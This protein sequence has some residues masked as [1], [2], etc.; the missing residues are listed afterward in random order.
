MAQENKIK[1]IYVGGADLY[2]IFKIG[3]Y[4]VCLSDRFTYNYMGA[5]YNIIFKNK[6][7]FGETYSITYKKNKYISDNVWIYNS[8]KI[9]KNKD[10]IK[11]HPLDV[12][13]DCIYLGSADF[14]NEEQKKI[15][16]KDIREFLKDEREHDRKH[17]DF[18][19]N[20]NILFN[21]VTRFE[22]N[23]EPFKFVLFEI[24]ENN[25]I[26]Y[27]VW[28]NLWGSIN[29]SIGN[30]FDDSNH[31][32]HSTY[33]LFDALCCIYSKIKKL[34]CGSKLSPDYPSDDDFDRRYNTMNIYE[35]N[36]DVMDKISVFFKL[37]KSYEN[38]ENKYPIQYDM[39]LSS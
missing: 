23:C 36:N 22:E 5:D 25:K 1:D 33:S 16:E 12:T 8:D 31:L 27:D 19:T 3:N 4:S 18:W 30:D 32:L 15:L 14:L 28:F 35:V 9:K 11:I 7:S 39:E 17:R 37:I 26:V 13:S 10:V 2:E 20:R 38:N 34:E 21:I 24:K 29:N 6:G